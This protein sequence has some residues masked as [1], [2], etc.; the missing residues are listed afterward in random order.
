MDWCD[1]HRTLGSKLDA[2]IFADFTGSSSCVSG[3]CAAGAHQQL[4]RC[5]ED[6][7]FWF[8]EQCWAVIRTGDA[9]GRW[10]VALPNYN[11]EAISVTLTVGKKVRY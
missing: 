5:C 9:E 10:V 6:S 1:R 2:W 3:M 4:V 8:E 7:Q 11:Q